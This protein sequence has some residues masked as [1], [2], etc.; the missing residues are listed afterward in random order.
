MRRSSSRT[1]KA[2]T[3]H[4][5]RRTTQSRGTRERA[6]QTQVRQYC[7]MYSRSTRLLLKTHFSYYSVRN[8]ESTLSQK[9]QRLTINHHKVSARFI[10]IFSEQDMLVAACAEQQQQQYHAQHGVTTNQ[11]PS[12]AE[13]PSHSNSNT[14]FLFAQGGSNKISRRPIMQSHGLWGMGC[15]GGGSVR[16]RDERYNV[17]SYR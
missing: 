3:G 12:P 17:R 1:S 9:T 11:L 15:V 4:H 8:L 7:C 2:P 10:D 6:L 13:R 14:S 5:Q 16:S